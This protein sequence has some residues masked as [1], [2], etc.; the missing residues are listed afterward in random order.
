MANPYVICR[1]LN[2]GSFQIE[3]KHEKL[4]ECHFGPGNIKSV[5]G[6]LLKSDKGVENFSS[7]PFVLLHPIPPPPP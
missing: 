3:I 4:E 1:M 6:K 2:L 7:L 5:S